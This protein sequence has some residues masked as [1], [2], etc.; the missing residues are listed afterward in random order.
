[1]TRNF[2]FFAF[3]RSNLAQW[4]S[5]TDSAV[6]RKK[7]CIVPHIFCTLSCVNDDSRNSASASPVLLNAI[8]AEGEQI[9]FIY[10]NSTLTVAF[11]YD[12]V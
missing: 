10:L 9:A 7:N 1:M 8:R 3:V 11:S 5:I 2:V 4:D 6:D 12:M